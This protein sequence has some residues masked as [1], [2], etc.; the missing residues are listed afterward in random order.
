M[1]CIWPE[2]GVLVLP[3]LLLYEGH[4][5]AQSQSGGDRLVPELLEPFKASHYQSM[6][7]FCG[8]LSI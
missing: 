5:D 7:G 3:R 2:C 4:L 1:N 6:V 8:F